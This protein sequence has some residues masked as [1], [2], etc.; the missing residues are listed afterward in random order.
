MPCRLPAV[1]RRLLQ[2][3]L[4]QRRP[5]RDDRVAGPSPPRPEQ[6]PGCSNRSLEDGDE[7]AFET[8]A[9]AVAAA[10]PALS[11]A[12][13]AGTALSSAAAGVEPGNHRLYSCARFATERRGRAGPVFTAAT[14]AL[15]APAADAR[16]RDRW[17]C[18]DFYRRVCSD[19]RVRHG[20][21]EQRLGRGDRG[22]PGRQVVRGSYS[23]RRRPHD[24]DLGV[25]LEAKAACVRDWGGRGG[26]PHKPPR[27]R[28]RRPG[29]PRRQC[30]PTTQRALR[31]LRSRAPPSSIW[32]SVKARTRP[33]R[34]ASASQAANAAASSPTPT[35]DATAAAASPFTALQISI[36][37]GAGT[38]SASSATALDTAGAQ[39]R[40]GRVGR[41]RRRCACA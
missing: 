41:Q 15:D 28:P 38:N 22:R 25:Q 33:G 9:P 26:R 13:D 19:C 37:P 2:P 27:P 3:R 16:D 1:L 4:P 10:T 21:I 30:R 11:G 18:S 23:D 39:L 34:A 29:R 7:D 24:P 5:A 31:R 6:L 17:F 36:M 8:A 14:T 35:A 20:A 32:R 40:G 12:A